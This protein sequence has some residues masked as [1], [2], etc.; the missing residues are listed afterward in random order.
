MKVGQI[1]ATAGRWLFILSIPALLLTASIGLAVNSQGLYQYGFDKYNVGQST[2]LDSSQLEKAAGGLIDY[3]NSGEESISLI[4]VKNDQPFTLFNERE[5]AHLRDVKGL[6]RL[7]YWILLATGIYFLAY[8]GVRLFRKTKE[9][10]RRL[11]WSVV[12]G[13]GATLGLILVL[14]LA[15][16]IDF[17]GFFLQ[18]HLLSFANDLWQLDPARDFLIMLFPKGFWFDATMLVVLVTVALAIILTAAAGLYIR[19]SGKK[20]EAPE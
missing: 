10:W 16:L 19:A 17:D 13:G 1:L 5:V 2:G 8:A 14:G 3:F 18:F 12:G 4:V 20:V 7:D 6:I 11:A 15:A 9:D